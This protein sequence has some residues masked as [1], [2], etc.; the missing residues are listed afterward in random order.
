M[1]ASLALS[2]LSYRSVVDTLV[3]EGSL[4]FHVGFCFNHAQNETA[5]ISPILIEQS[6]LG[7]PIY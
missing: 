5:A 1:R 2:A 3:L 4:E 6:S 7:K